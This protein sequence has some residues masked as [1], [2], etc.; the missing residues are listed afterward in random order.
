MKILIEEIHINEG[1]RSLDPIHVREL[2]DS[3][4]ELGLLNPP[5]VERDNTTTTQSVLLVKLIEPPCTERYARWLAYH[6]LIQCTQ[7]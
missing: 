7:A 5:T 3:I 6:N 1:R 2:A 4:R